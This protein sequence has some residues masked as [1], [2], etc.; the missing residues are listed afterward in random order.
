M[1][2]ANRSAR[3]RDES[4]RENSPCENRASAIDKSGQRWHMQSGVQRDDPHAQERNG[5]QLYKSAQVIPWREQ[6]PHWHGRGSESIHDDQQSQS[7]GT[8][9]KDPSQCRMLRYELASPDRQHHE[10]ESKNGNFQYFARTNAT[11][12]N[13]HQ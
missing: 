11:Q 2:A 9:S 13:S 7:G 8:K 3:N 4:K 10:N 6:Q 12:I 5:P 1:E